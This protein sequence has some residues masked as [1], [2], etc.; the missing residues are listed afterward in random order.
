MLLKAKGMNKESEVIY[1]KLILPFCLDKPKQMHQMKSNPL[2]SYLNNSNAIINNKI[3]L[4]NIVDQ[5]V[6]K[7]LLLIIYLGQNNKNKTPVERMKIKEKV[8]NEVLSLNKIE[9]EIVHL[10]LIDNPQSYNAKIVYSKT[11][12]V[13]NK[14]SIDNDI[15]NQVQQESVFNPLVNMKDINT[16][17]RI[18]KY[19]NEIIDTNSSYSLPTT[20]TTT[21]ADS[22]YVNDPHSN[23][24]ILNKSNQKKNSKP[25][26]MIIKYE[27]CLLKHFNPK[28]IRKEEID[29]KIFR[30]FR[31]CIKDFMQKQP[32]FFRT[33]DKE[34]WD[35]FVNKRLLPPMRYQGKD[36]KVVEFKSFSTKYF[37][38]LFSQKGTTKLYNAF[39]N[40][41]EEKFLDYLKESTH[42]KILIEK[43]AITKIGYYMRHIPCVYSSS[44][45]EDGEYIV[46]ICSCTDYRF[47]FDKILFDKDEPQTNQCTNTFELKHPDFE[48]N[49]VSL[50][51]KKDDYYQKQIGYDKDEQ[52][53]ENNNVLFTNQ[54]YTVLNDNKLQ[55]EDDDTFCSESKFFDV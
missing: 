36:N 11:S 17:R 20:A 42:I 18:K 12:N 35:D 5:Y 4:K 29:K 48:N 47:E 22:I 34:F 21:V 7:I 6:N 9:K 15:F 45:V 32:N 16:K 10:F 39:V 52:M 14:Q 3:Q 31:V 49:Y 28:D 55:S 51:T 37:V 1:S 44:W 19:T 33:L 54:D 40:L 30:I 46:P 38:W 26:G 53:N 50:L 41:Y 27:N 2:Y 23:F 8:K 13:N 24:S 25:N 43:E